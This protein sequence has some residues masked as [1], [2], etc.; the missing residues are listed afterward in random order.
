[1]T[2]GMHKLRL[3]GSSLKAAS[4]AVSTGQALAVSS[5]DHLLGVQPQELLAVQMPALKRTQVTCQTPV[6]IACSSAQV[7]QGHDCWKPTLQKGCQAL[8]PQLESRL[9]AQAQQL[10]E[11]TEHQG[12][13]WPDSK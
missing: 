4:A 11:W 8:L 6:P 10:A 12:G 5:A 13:G 2:S 3:P 9:K 7:L 1:M